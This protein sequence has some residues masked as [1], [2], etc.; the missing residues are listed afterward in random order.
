[1]WHGRVR[2]GTA[3]DLQVGVGQEGDRVATVR[4]AAVRAAAS[5]GHVDGGG[6]EQDL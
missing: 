6:G 1:M 2:G 4:G 5:G 3:W